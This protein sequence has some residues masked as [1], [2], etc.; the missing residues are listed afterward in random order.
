M[1]RSRASAQS[2]GMT[3]ISRTQRAA[4]LAVSLAL[5]L[6]WS[7]QS[8]AHLGLET[9]TPAE[10]STIETAPTEASLTFSAP[11]DLETA[12]AA[13]RYLG[14]IDTPLTEVTNRDVK[15]E[16]LVRKAAADR[17]VV[18]TLPLLDPGTYAIDWAVNESG[19]HEN[20]SMILFRVTGASGSNVPLN[21]TALLSMV[22]IGF[23]A[24][25][26]TSRGRK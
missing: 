15:T 14:D 22:A 7:S 2:T 6:S 18:F 9:S 25:R 21:I 26:L 4:F 3:R 19:G 13:L 8:S 24:V 1:R 12:T 16:Q 23:L 11:V 20:A 17:T 10:G 5:S